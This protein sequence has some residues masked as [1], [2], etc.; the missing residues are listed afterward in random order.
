ML[1][2]IYWL[3][4]IF[5][6]RVYNTLLGGGIRYYKG[7]KLYLSKNVFSPIR[8]ISTDLIVDYIEA[9]E[10]EVENKLV[11]DL[12]TGSGAIAIYCAKKSAKVVASDINPL[13]IRIARI[14]SFLNNVKVDLRLCDLFECYDKDE[15]FN[16]IIFNPPYFPV[17]IRNYIDA[18]YA[19]GRNYSTIIRFL[20]FS[21]KRLMRNGY[22][23][24]TLSSLINANLIL[25]IARRIGYSVERVLERK[26][27]PFE[28][29]S[30]YKLSLDS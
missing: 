13:A 6:I 7:M 18:M 28:T 4:I 20:A 2:F 22:I 29:I 19:C 16:I 10:K 26:G 21:K 24:I 30:L 23:L 8:T 9:N 3:F 27:M 12:G 11:C 14:N 1:L 15:K 17:K 5:L 25:K